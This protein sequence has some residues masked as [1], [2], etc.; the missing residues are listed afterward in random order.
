MERSGWATALLAKSRERAEQHQQRPYP[1]HPNGNVHHRADTGSVESAACSPGSSVCWWSRCSCPRARRRRRA[2]QH[3]KFRYGPV[4]IKPGQNTISI[5]GDGVPKPK[6]P[7]WIVGFRPNLERDERVDP[8]RRRPA[9]APRGLA[10]Q[11]RADVRGRRGEDERQAAEGLRL[12]PRARRP[13]GAQPHGP[14]PAAQPRPRVPHL[15]ARLHPRLV[16]GGEGHAAGR[17]ALARRPGRQG[18]PRL[19]RAS[20]AAA[21]TA[22]SPTRTTCPA[23]TGAGRGST[24]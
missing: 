17:D 24:S 6:R 22:A 3:L 7:G 20:A 19:R 8:A 18:V 23:P 12:A 5:D 2:S 13:L 14:Q 16:A 4:T 9:P 10:D 21:A 11:R 15:H 1:P